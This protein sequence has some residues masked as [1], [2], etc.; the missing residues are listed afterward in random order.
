MERV[1]IRVTSLLSLLEEEQGLVVL[2][3]RALERDEEPSDQ[4]KKELRAVRMRIAE[5]LR[6]FQNGYLR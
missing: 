3:N 6:D 2:M 1:K 5:K 4:A